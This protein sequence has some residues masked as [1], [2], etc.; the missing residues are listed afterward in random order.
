MSFKLIEK[1][2][3]FSGIMQRTSAK[4]E[5]LTEKHTTSMAAHMR[6]LMPVKTGAMR[7]STETVKVAQNFWAIIIGQ[8]YWVFVNSG[9]VY[10]Q[11]KHFVEQAFE[12]AKAEFDAE[13]RSGALQV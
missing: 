6:G 7:D 2:N 8:P 3:R 11:G 13:I 4:A 1:S 5:F 12:R 10:I 9:T